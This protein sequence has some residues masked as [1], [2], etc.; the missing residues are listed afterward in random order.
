MPRRGK[1]SKVRAS[2][3]ND[4]FYNQKIQQVLNLQQESNQEAKYSEES[5]TTEE[6]KESE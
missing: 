6:Y 4:F 2:E 3:N 5:K 1:S